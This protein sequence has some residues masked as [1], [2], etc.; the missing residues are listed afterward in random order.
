VRQGAQYELTL[1]AETLSISGAAIPK[2]EEERLSPLEKRI[3]RLES[4]RHLSQ[5]LDLLYE[6]YLC[7]RNGSGWNDELGRIRQWLQAA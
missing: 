7:R 1:Q 4:L 6:T 2:A 3:G 5:T